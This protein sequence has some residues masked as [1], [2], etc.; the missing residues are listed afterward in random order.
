MRLSELPSTTSFRLS[1]LFLGLFGGAS[2]V[3]FAALYWQTVGYLKSNVDSWL[4]RESA[5]FASASPAILRKRLNTHATVRPEGN[6]PYA[7]FSPGGKQIAGTPFLLPKRVVFGHPFEFEENSNGRT[8]P[9][10][11][12]MRRL[13]SGDMLLIA[14]DVQEMDEFRNLLVNAMARGGLLALLIGFAGAALIGMKTIQK[15]NSVT[16]SIERIVKG[17]LSE[18]LPSRGQTGD[19][20]RLIAVVNGMLEEIER[21]MHRV[22]GVSNDITHDLR[23]PLTR[24]LAGLERARR[25]AH[26]P[27]E[28]ASAIDAAVSE[29]KEILGT[30]AALLRIAEIEDGARRREFRALDLNVIAAEVAEFYAP[31]ADDRLVSLQLKSLPETPAEILGDASLLFDALGNLVDN[32][33]KFAPPNSSVFIHVVHTASAT[34]ITVSD[35]GPGIRPEERKE[36]LQRFYRGEES[37]HK[38]GAGLGLSLVAAVAQLHDLRLQFEDGDPGLIVSLLSR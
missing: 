22:K 27:Q 26:S 3:L 31:L 35:Q 21:L 25:R 18:R 16:D 1:L 23:T 33:I 2:L 19:L 6:R 8:L 34:G 29:T 5:S 13:P 24:L 36:V 28:F 20:D 10:R 37:R 15:I 38:P 30:F 9:Y 12:L 4:T 32:A 11:G 17:N 14:Q 7:L